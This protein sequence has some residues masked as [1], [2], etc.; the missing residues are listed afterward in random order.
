[1]IKIFFES[2]DIKTPQLRFSNV[3]TIIEGDSLSM[4]CEVE[5]TPPVYFKWWKNGN[6]LNHS[7]STIILKINRNDS[8]IYQ[9]QAGNDAGIK[10]S[11]E[12]PLNVMCE[13]QIQFFYFIETL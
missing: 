1:M 11:N 9:C 2:L 12:H 4:F 13:F 6:V 10:S 8:G 3:E 7:S 5:S